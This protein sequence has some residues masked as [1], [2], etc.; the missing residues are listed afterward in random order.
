MGSFKRGY[1]RFLEVFALP[2]ESLLLSITYLL[3][4]AIPRLLRTLKGGS[5]WYTQSRDIESY[6]EEA[7]D[8][9]QDEVSHYSQF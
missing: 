3:G 2:I 9:P 1:F 4:F 6:W 5:G 7:E 8:Y